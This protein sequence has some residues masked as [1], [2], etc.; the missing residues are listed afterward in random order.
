MYLYHIFYQLLNNI[1][2][3][4]IYIYRIYSIRTVTGSDTACIL[5]VGDPLLKLDHEDMVSF[6]RGNF[7]TVRMHATTEYSN[8]ACQHILLTC[9]NPRKWPK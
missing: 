2:F 7:V 5:T 4:A 6:G 8:E 1:F 9:G 3:S